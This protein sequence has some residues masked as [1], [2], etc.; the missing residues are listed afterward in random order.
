VGAAEG[1]DRDVCGDGISGLNGERDG[2][3]GI[4]ARREGTGRGG[5]HGGGGVEREG[6]ERENREEGGGELHFVSASFGPS[7]Q[8]M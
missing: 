8:R 1:D 3:R 6:G 7:A 2:R 5:V 4:K